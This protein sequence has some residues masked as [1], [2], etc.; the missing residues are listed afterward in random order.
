MDSKS[1]PAD[2]DQV[3]GGVE[4]KVVVEQQDPLETIEIRVLA[5]RVADNKTIKRSATKDFDEAF[6]RA[7]GATIRKDLGLDSMATIQARSTIKGLSIASQPT[8]SKLLGVDG[9]SET[10]RAIG[11]GNR[12]EFL[13]LSASI[14][15]QFR[16]HNSALHSAVFGMQNTNLLRL[17]QKAN[18]VPISNAFAVQHS[19]Q[20]KRLVDSFAIPK[21]VF[22]SDLTRLLASEIQLGS[23]STQLIGSMAR[24][25]LVRGFDLQSISE[26]STRAL[27][28]VVEAIPT[29]NPGPYLQH[30]TLAG[31][32]TLATSRALEILV[33]GEPESEVPLPGSGFLPGS[34]L[35]HRDL[36]DRLRLLNPNLVRRLEGAWE[37]VTGNGV[38]ATS[39]ACHS[40]QELLDWT[41]RL[42][43]PD[44][45]VLDWHRETGR[46]SNELNKERPTRSLKAKYLLRNRPQDAKAG[47]F[48]IRTLDELSG[49]LQSGKHSL[50]VAHRPHVLGHVL[51]SVEALLGFLLLE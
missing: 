35:M 40:V 31:L 23:I 45:L 7:S 10:Q 32:D 8:L 11:F 2:G 42:A 20:I 36:V 38:D 43:A 6:R 39:Q 34:L 24:L 29:D 28:S 50:D 4:D 22:G 37:Q 5:D 25:N 47:R 33:G 44:E 14:A 15:D 13:K 26:L 9:L 17:F 1:V 41:L 48:Y 18:F 30:A 19:E 51:Q 46:D 49:V 16:P 12:S 21:T 3:D 27:R